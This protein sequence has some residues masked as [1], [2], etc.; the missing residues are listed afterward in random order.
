MLFKTL[1]IQSVHEEIKGFKTFSF[2]PG[3]DIHYEAGQYLTFV[4]Q[5][6]REEIRRSYSITSTPLLGEILSIGVKRIENGAFSRHL[7][8][9]ARPGDRLITSGAGGFFT[10]PQNMDQYQQL[11]F[12]SAGSGITPVFSLLKTLLHIYQHTSA[13]L[14]YSNASIHTTIFYQELIQLREKFPKRFQL[15]FLFSDSP[16]LKRARLN[17]ELFT[18]LLHHLMN[19]E[20]ER[21]LFYICGP[22]TYMRMCTY[23][24]QEQGVHPDHIRKENFIIEKRLPPRPSPPDPQ[25]RNVFIKYGTAHYNFSVSYPLSILEAAKKQKIELPYSCETGRCGSCVGRCKSGSV[26]MSYNEVLTEKDLQQG[27][28]LTCVGHPVG[29]DVA[30]EI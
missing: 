30:L 26:W 21:I 9:H 11:F 16:D 15:H 8:D 24:L 28:V 22:E 3:H 13:V 27:L 2:E 18:E 17:R 6:H 12:F 25:T 20:F 14:I 7:I 1:T 5:V 19:F 10:L 23:I 4:H 29:G